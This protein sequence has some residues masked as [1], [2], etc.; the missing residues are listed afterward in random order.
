MA[1]QETSC[2]YFA[3]SSLSMALAIS[4]GK[5]RISRRDSLRRRCIGLCG[6]KWCASIGELYAPV[7]REGKRGKVF[8]EKCPKKN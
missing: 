8:A 2:D 4:Q 7:N 3:F 5:C 6:A 1:R